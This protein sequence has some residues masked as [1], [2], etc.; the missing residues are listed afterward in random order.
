MSTIIFPS[1]SQQRHEYK[2]RKM[3]ETRIY[4]QSFLKKILIQTS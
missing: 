4:V 2:T 1:D 3:L